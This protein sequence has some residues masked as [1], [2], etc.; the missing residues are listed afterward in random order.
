M[1]LKTKRSFLFFSHP[2][3]WSEIQ[4]VEH[5]NIG[6]LHV[7][8]VGIEDKIP[9]F[10]DEVN[11]YAEMLSETEEDATDSEV[12]K[13]TTTNSGELFTLLCLFLAVDWENNTYSIRREQILFSP[14]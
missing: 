7:I 12:L 6:P 13:E 4:D 3:V 2:S 11:D 14:F 9:D 10:H 8:N 5:E 1:Y